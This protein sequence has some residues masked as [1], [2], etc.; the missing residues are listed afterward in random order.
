MTSSAT[1]EG[2][3]ALPS[4]QHSTATTNH[5]RAREVS[6]P[7]GGAGRG[8][9]VSHSEVEREKMERRV[10]EAILTQPLHASSVASMGTTA[11][12]V[13]H[14]SHHWETG[15]QLRSRSKQPSNWQFSPAVV[16]SMPSNRTMPVHPY[17]PSSTPPPSSTLP[18]TLPNTP[19]SS[20]SHQYLLQQSISQ[21]WTDYTSAPTGATQT[22]PNNSTASVSG[23]VLESTQD[24]SEF[25]PIQH[26]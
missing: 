23:F 8:D 11:T 16:Y 10:R 15:D 7:A 18:S 17:L 1:G 26:S 24:I 20:S 5:P 22:V 6:A 3:P 25:D 21:E 9:S 2:H 12:T 13:P 19:S 14:S 4:R